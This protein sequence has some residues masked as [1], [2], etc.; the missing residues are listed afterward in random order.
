MP[1]TPSRS[2]TRYGPNCSSEAASGPIAQRVDR[3]TQR[4]TA[5]RLLL[6][7]FGRS[8]VE[9]EGMDRPL[10]FL[11]KC[12]HDEAVSLQHGSTGEPG[13]NDRGFPVVLGAGEVR[14]LDDRIRE[15]RADLRDDGVG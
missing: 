5:I 11:D 4:T 3:R 13:R 7:F 6:R 12:R 14:K 8:Y 2:Y 9:R 1:P 10:H 15:C